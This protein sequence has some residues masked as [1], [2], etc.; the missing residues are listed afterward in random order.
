[1]FGSNCFQ[2]F[3]YQI[4]QALLQYNNTVYPAAMYSSDTFNNIYKTHEGK[5]KVLYWMYENNVFL[6]LVVD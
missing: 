5:Y 1:M 2:G 3:E 6:K 4:L